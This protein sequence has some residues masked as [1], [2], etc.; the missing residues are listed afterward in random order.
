MIQI[1]DFGKNLGVRIFLSPACGQKAR[2]TQTA[3]TPP[4]SPETTYTL[5]AVEGIIK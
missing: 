4:D 1:I 5:G 2:T 3:R